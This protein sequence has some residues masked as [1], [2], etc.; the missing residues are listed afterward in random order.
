MVALVLKRSSRVMPDHDIDDQH[1]VNAQSQRNLTGL[2]GDTG[3]DD[4]DVGS[5]E[6]SCEL[7]VA[8]EASDLLTS[9]FACEISS[10]HSKLTLVGVSMWL[11]SAATP[12][13]I[14]MNETNQ[15]PHVHANPWCARGRR[16]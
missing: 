8:N 15:E 9:C 1:C 10:A 4:D 12:E 5:L 11:I 3:G 7:I 2:A 6:R 13:D 14:W 16:R